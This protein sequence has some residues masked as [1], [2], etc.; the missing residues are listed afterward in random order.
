MANKKDKEE[1]LK[2]Q[3][4]KKFETEAGEDQPAAGKKTPAGEDPD[5]VPDEFIATK[6]DIDEPVD[7]QVRN[8]A[9]LRGEDHANDKLFS[10]PA[11]K[12]RNEKED[13]R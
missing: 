6:P 12:D 3:A 2:K 10:S 13:D 8:D 4:R 1:G 7:R 5:T 11:E 9:V